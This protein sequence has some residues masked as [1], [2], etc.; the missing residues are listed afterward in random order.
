MIDTHT[1][2]YETEFDADADEVVARAKEAGVS[3]VLLP[4]ID[5][6]S[7]PRMLAFQKRFPDFCRM[8]CGIHPTSVNENYKE[9]LKRFEREI[10][11]HDF[12]AVGEIGM[13]LYWDK[14]FVAEQRLVF[15]HQL[16][17]AVER[18]L[19]VSIHCRD[20]FAETI[21]SLKKF[22]PAK[23][24]GVFHAFGGVVD[25][26]RE[27]FACGR[28]KLGIGGV[29]TYKNA[30]F[31]ERL[32]EIPLESLVLETDA[33]YLTPVPY[34]GK[35]NEPA[36]LQYVA[37]RLAVLYGVTAEKVDTITTRSAREIFLL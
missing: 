23:L 36:Y 37:E 14:T 24:R 29:C 7:Y 32:P 8:M 31:A 11:R 6:A 21:A 13:D 15:E 19:P 22:D 4:D 2:I 9:E 27:I 20:A 1:H 16:A 28:F 3:M 12:V 18:D 5:A 25:N 17:M 26:A 34:R 30:K 10:D 35:R 33:P